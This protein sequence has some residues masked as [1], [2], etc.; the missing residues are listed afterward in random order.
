MSRNFR[1]LVALVLV[2]AFFL[3]ALPGTCRAADLFAPDMG[4]SGDT[5]SDGAVLTVGLFAAVLVVLAL[6]NAKTDIDNVFGK[7]EPAKSKAALVLAD[8]GQRIVADQAMAGSESPV[9]G[10]GLGVRMQF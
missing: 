8:P 6:I 2:P 4:V 9:D 7:S 1:R 5:S 3:V 10:L